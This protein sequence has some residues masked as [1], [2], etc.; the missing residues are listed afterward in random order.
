MT[1][2]REGRPAGRLAA[3]GG[4][5]FLSL[6]GPEGAGKTT[7]GGLLAEYLRRRGRDVIAVREP[8]GTPIGEEIRAILLDPRHQRL[9][10]RAEMLLFAASRA[11]LV[12][13]VIAPALRAGKWVISDRFLDASLAYQGVGRGLGVEVVREVNVAATGGLLPDLTLL[14]DIDAATGLRRARAAS[15]GSGISDRLEQEQ[16]SFHERV[17]Q[18]FLSLAQNEPERIRVVD[19]RGTVSGVQREIRQAVAQMLR[20]RDRGPAGRG[21]DEADPR[22][23]SR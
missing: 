6:E 16:V 18:G 21:P 12:A 4:G 11:Q 5:F 2:H 13:E 1:S 14:L 23:C 7:Q 10:A 9:T 20:R 8:G 17:R 3:A 15:A 22:D 19:A